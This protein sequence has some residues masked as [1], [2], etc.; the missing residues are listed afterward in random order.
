MARSRA[1]P[2]AGPPAPPSRRS[3]P[4]PAAA[5]C[6]PACLAWSELDP[7]Q[8]EEVVNRENE[9]GHDVGQVDHIGAAQRMHPSA[10]TE[11]EDRAIVLVDEQGGGS[12]VLHIPGAAAEQA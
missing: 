10:G 2:R 4:A 8:S 1:P 9:A 11:Q 12:V 5:V 6:S 3:R 7:H